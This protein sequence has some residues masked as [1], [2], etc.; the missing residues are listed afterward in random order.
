LYPIR[1]VGQA[2]LPSCE[3]LAKNFDL[4]T[5]MVDLA[6]VDESKQKTL[7]KDL[8]G[9]DANAIAEAKQIPLLAAVTAAICLRVC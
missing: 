7:T 1:C 5:I 8:D 4:A 6:G 9:K 2:E 3:L